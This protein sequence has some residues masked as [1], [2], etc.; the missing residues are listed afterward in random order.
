MSNYVCNVCGYIYNES[1][2][3][4]QDGILPN[5]FW[6][7]VPSNWLC[8]VCKA[9][10]QDF[11][12]QKTNL[13]PPAQTPLLD[14]HPEKHKEL[15]F[16]E[17][18]ALCSNLA[19]GCEK[20]YLIQEAE[21]FLELASYFKRLTTPVLEDRLTDLLPLIEEDLSKSYPPAFHVAEQFQDRGALRALTWSEKV[22]RILSSLLNRYLEQGD[23]LLSHTNI[24]VCEICGFIYLGE[25]PPDICPICK[26]PNQ[27]IALVFKGVA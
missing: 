7:Q 13:D 10:K 24:Y 20:Q 9:T 8:P 18:S 6:N 19:K 14:Y 25:A 16:I 22:T 3:H 17:L 2:G 11:S 27:K 15:N 26:V 23:A 12:L 21:L 5:T 4:P 1:T